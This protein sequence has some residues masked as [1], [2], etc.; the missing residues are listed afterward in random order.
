L[1]GALLLLALGA[2]CATSPQETTGAAADATPVADPPLAVEI[3][4]NSGVS[5]RELRAAARRELRALEER[6]RPADAADAAWAMEGAL[7]GAGFAHGSVEFELT[8]TRALFKVTMGPRAALG[9]VLFEGVRRLDVAELERFFA[10][11][12]AGLFGG[13]SPP[14][15]RSQVE[16]AASEVERHYLLNGFLDAV[17]DPPMVTWNADRTRADITIHVAE[18]RRY[19]V[20]AIEMYGLEED[21]PME[22][23]GRPYHPRLPVEASASVRRKLYD[24]GHQFAQVKSSRSINRDHALVTIRLEVKPGPIVKLRRLEITGPERTKEWFLKSLIPIEE[25]D[26]LLQRFIDRARENLHQSGLFT[27]IFTDMERVGEDQV[28]LKLRLVEREARHIDF[29]VGWGSYERLRGAVRYSDANIFGIGRRLTTRVFASTRSFGVDGVISDPW[30]LGDRNRIEIIGGASYREE[31]SFDRLSFG[32]GV[33]MTHRTKRGN[34]LIL[35]YVW[36]DEQAQNNR[37]PLPPGV[38]EEFIATGTVFVSLRID[39][40]DDVLTPTRGFLLEASLGY[41]APWLGGDLHFADVNVAA[42]WYINLGQRNVFAVGIRGQTRPILD[43]RRT[44]P[45]QERIFLGGDNTVRSFD[46]DQLGPS[47]GGVATG[48]LT[49]VW[50]SME[51]RTQVWGDLFSAIFYDVGFVSLDS[52][53]YV[54][55]PG[56][57][58]GLGARYMLPVGPIRVD[59]AY[60]PGDLFAA[61]RRWQIHLSVGF[62]F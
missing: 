55:P 23:V 21:L 16:S 46:R 49:R 53:S 33:T 61:E 50:F 44:L 48:G 20:I 36:K 39:R 31:P 51:L 12:G 10:F 24:K 9:D 18:G 11:P 13:K 14:F 43:N 54:G 4:G 27:G 45:I 34:T 42:S 35:G 5:T 7:H 8:G 1:R 59:L 57:G 29:E 56:H 62:S 52:F 58:I 60:N 40:T 22:L 28:D 19:V 17:V 15:Q 25:G 6:R 2:A 37:L 32:A 26:A 41:S 38:N 30:L 3:S 47:L